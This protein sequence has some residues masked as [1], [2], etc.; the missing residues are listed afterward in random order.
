[1]AMRML[2]LFEL[3]S[4]DGPCLDCYCTVGPVVNQDLATGNAPWP[5]FGPEALAAGFRSVHALPGTVIGALN[6]FHVEPE[7]V[8]SSKRTAYGTVVDLTAAGYTVKEKDGRRNRYH[9]QAH[10]PLRASM[11]RGRTVGQLVDLLSMATRQGP[12]APGV[13]DIPLAAPCHAGLPV[14]LLAGGRA[15]CSS[16]RL[17]EDARGRLGR[18]DHGVEG[19]VA[20]YWPSPWRPG[21][22][23]G[24]GETLVALLVVGQAVVEEGDPHWAISS[25][26]SSP[27]HRR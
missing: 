17:D 9:I 5:R 18:A 15:R 26:R 7:E 25:H 19:P 2:E 1:M 20:R 6:L 16:L 27:V 13:R 22:A 14:A 12:P 8:R 24:G 10:Q 11:S 4:H 21:D 23:L 3:Q